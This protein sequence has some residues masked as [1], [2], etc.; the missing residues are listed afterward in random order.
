MNVALIAQGILVMW[1]D[2]GIKMILYL[3][4]VRPVREDRWDTGLLVAE[5]HFGLQRKPRHSMQQQ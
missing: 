4:S 2:G 3:Q 1:S 5:I